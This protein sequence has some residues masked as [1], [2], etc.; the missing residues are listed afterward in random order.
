M[1]RTLALGV[2]LLV[3]ISA[4]CVQSQGSTP[5]QTPIPATSEPSTSAVSTETP[6]EVSQKALSGFNIDIG[7]NDDA[8][9]LVIYIEVRNQTNYTRIDGTLNLTIK[10]RY[11]FLIY[12]GSI[13]V[14]KSDFEPYTKEFTGLDD[15]LHNITHYKARYIIP[16]P[17]KGLVSEGYIHAVLIVGNQTLKRDFIAYDLPEMSDDEKEAY[18]EN[19]YLNNSRTLNIS[20]KHGEL[21]VEVYRYGV[22]TNPENLK[23][24]LRV[25]VRIRNTANY[26]VEIDKLTLGPLVVDGYPIKAVQDQD[27]FLGE[28]AKDEYIKKSLLFPMSEIPLSHQNLNLKLGIK[29]D[30]PEQ[31]ALISLDRLPLKISRWPFNITISDF[32]TGT[33]EFIGTKETVA[34]V[35]VLVRNNK[36]L[37]AEMVPFFMWELSG[38][39]PSI[40]SKVPYDIPA[41]SEAKAILVYYFD[42]KPNRWTLRIAFPPTQR[43]LQ[44]E[45]ALPPLSFS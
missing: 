29:E 12:N 34:N 13:E 28:L 43:E 23:K 2:I 32:T 7:Y 31:E 27:Y 40:D 38:E 36:K 42:Q 45:V 25:D 11:S 39:S 37:V 5:S 1:R 26:T 33:V 18:F 21:R 24:Y 35:T 4:G 16:H 30:L 10:D 14:K 22:Y 6:V 44:F 19:L 8:D 17:R 41:H 15:K 3:V 20:Q 9:A